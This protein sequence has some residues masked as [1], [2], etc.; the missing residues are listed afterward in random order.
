MKNTKFKYKQ[1][2]FNL[3]TLVSDKIEV[4]KLKDIFIINFLNQLLNF[5]IIKEFLIVFEFLEISS[6]SF[7]CFNDGNKPKEG[8]ILK[9]V[10][11]RLCR[12]L[13][14]CLCP[15]ISCCCRVWN[16]RWF[17]LKDDMICYL[18]SSMTAMGKDVSI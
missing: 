1:I 15:C 12:S 16:K 9:Q 6:Q 10:D 3:D 17:V 14:F 18:E 2:S 4:M 7:H 8:Y 13:M 5:Q 11:P